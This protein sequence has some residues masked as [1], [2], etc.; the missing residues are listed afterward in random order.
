MNQI[1][2][3]VI[4]FISSIFITRLLGA[5]G[6]GDYAVFSN[7][8]TL[9]SVWLGLSLPSSII[10]F[11]GSKKIDSGK[12]LSNG[13]ALVLITSLLLFLFLKILFFYNRQWVVFPTKYQSNL[14]QLLFIVQFFLVQV[15]AII[16]AFLVANKIFI[17]QSIFNTAS[18]IFNMLLWLLIF[19][20]VINPGISGFGLVVVIVFLL[21]VPNLLFLIIVLIKKTNIRP[22]FQLM[23]FVEL[24]AMF[25]FSAI[26]YIT[27]AIQFFTYRMDIWF[28]DYYHGKAETGIYSLAVGLTQLLWI[29]PSAI[30]TVIYSYT[31][32]AN[33]E[34]NISF[35]IARSCRFTFTLSLSLGLLG[36][37][38]SY[39]FVPVFFGE[40]FLKT[41]SL[42]A[43]LL[44][45]IIPFSVTTVLGSYLAGINLPK[46]NLYAVL[47]GFTICLF[48][49]I[50]LI[51][52]MGSI[53]ASI[54]TSVSYISITIYTIIVFKKSSNLNYKNIFFVNKEDASII[55]K[56]FKK[57]KA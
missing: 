23:K 46:Q 25:F 6:K 47:V 24:K 50:T 39:L 32:S 13:I 37:G 2:T 38:L 15:A 11:A 42:M 29:F 52:T 56:L 43:L 27:N 54:A 1:I 3:M 55:K 26:L 14:W 34:D 30:A 36:L 45:G 8:I 10:Y 7:A 28:V 12:M 9:A 51:K 57:A 16:N 53:G 48:L 20:N 41:S 22:T 5:E 44:I 49:D 17:P 21:S 33:A 31:A 18:V 40:I 19:Y 4:G 35:M